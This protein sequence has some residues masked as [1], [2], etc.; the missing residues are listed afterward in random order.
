MNDEV[1]LNLKFLRGKPIK[2]NNVGYLYPVKIGDIEEITIEKYNRYLNLLCLDKNDIKELLKIQDD[3]FES[4][5]F[6]YLN[7]IRSKDFLSIVIEALEFF[8]KEKVTFNIPVFYLGELKEERY[9]HK[10]NFEEIKLLIKK[11]NCLIS[12][13]SKEEE[14]YKPVNEKA[15][16]ILEKFKKDNEIRKKIKQKENKEN[17]LDLFDLVSILSAYGSGINV[18][19]VWDLTFFQF[20]NQ[21]NRMKILKD[22]EVNIQILLNTTEPDKVKYQHWLSK[23][24]KE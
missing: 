6:I 17:S 23:I 20:N 12:E 9:I 5:D 14:I 21:F 24:V 22:F 11:M 7:C 2:I 13:K 19:N 1:N 15:R 18:F 10:N 3:D 8:F 16:K 4:F